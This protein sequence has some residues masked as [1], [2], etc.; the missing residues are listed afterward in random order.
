[1]DENTRKLWMPLSKSA[2]GDFVGI[3]SDTSIDRDEEFM[4]KE[5]LDNWARKTAPLPMLANHENKLE[6]LIGGW[7]DKKV[8]SKNGSNALV[9]KPFFLKS[10]PLGVQAEEMVKEALEKGM[11]IG[12]SIGAIPKGE[13][14]E[15]KINGQVFKGFNEAEILEATIVPLQSN[16]NASFTAMAKSFDINKEDDVK[17]SEEINKEEAPVQEEVKAEE[18]APVEEEK[19]EDPVEEKPAEEPVKEEAKPEEEKVDGQAEVDALKQENAELKKKLEEALSKTIMKAT[20]E[21]PI[22][23]EENLKKEVPLTVKE[24]LSLRYKK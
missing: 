1:M 10:N 14:V 17:M 13:M 12:I 20:V 22:D 15:K 3:L 21:G 5:L 4:T 2:N 9:A 11:G 19:K 8:I 16:R 6:K 7:T 24:M 23:H 18:V